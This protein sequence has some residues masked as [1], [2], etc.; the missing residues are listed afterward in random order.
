MKKGKSVVVK[1]GDIV[2]VCGALIIALCIAELIAYGGDGWTL[3]ELA[4]G[5]AFV[6]FGAY[7]N[8]R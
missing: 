6:M 8:S 5:V 1:A 2:G 4:R 3:A 7:M